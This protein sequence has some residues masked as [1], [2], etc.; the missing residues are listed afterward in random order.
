V[1]QNCQQTMRMYHSIAVQQQ[2]HYTDKRFQFPTKPATVHFFCRF[3]FRINACFRANCKKT[4]TKYIRS[5]LSPFKTSLFYWTHSQA[6]KLPTMKM[7][8]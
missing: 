2:L 5:E 3:A 1:Q 6:R 7:T 8:T 4:N